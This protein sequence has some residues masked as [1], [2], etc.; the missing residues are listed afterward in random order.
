MNNVVIT[1]LDPI[2]VPLVK[3]FYKEHYPTGKVNKSELVYSLTCER[4]LKGVVRFRAI[5]KYRLMTGMVI[6]KESRGLRLGDK[7]M[8][9]CIENTLTQHDYCF[10][11]EHLEHFYTKHNFIKIE[12]RSL[13]S[14]LLSLFDRYTNSGKALIP[15]HYQSNC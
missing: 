6:A 10:A 3:R 1:Q 13:P 7:L 15:M 2:K 14:C 8:E 9:F 12:P 5:E 11:Y 4:E